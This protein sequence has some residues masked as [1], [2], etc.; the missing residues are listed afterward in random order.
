MYQVCGSLE[1]NIQKPAVTARFRQFLPTEYPEVQH[2]RKFP[3]PLFR[4]LCPHCCGLRLQCSISN[5]GNAVDQLL[6]NLGLGNATPGVNTTLGG[7]GT[8]VNGLTTIVGLLLYVLGTLLGGNIPGVNAGGSGNPL[9]AVTSLLN[10][11]KL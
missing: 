6:Q 10:N 8:L 1:L 11:L 4:S 7:L 2:G 5:D 9:S 3:S